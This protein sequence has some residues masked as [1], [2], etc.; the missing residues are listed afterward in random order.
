M[1]TFEQEFEKIQKRYN[2]G[3]DIVSKKTMQDSIFKNPCVLYGCGVFG[4]VLYE[5]FTR[6]GRKI[7]CFVDGNK[8]GIESTSGLEIISPDELVLRYPNASIC[9]SVVTPRPA[10]EIRNK[11]YDLGFGEDQIFDFPYKLITTPFGMETISLSYEE[12]QNHRQG[13]EYAYNLFDDDISKSIVIDRINSLLFRDYMPYI[14][15][16]ECYFPADLFSLTDKEVFVD[17]GV[18]TGDTIEEFY[19]RTDG[20]YKKIIGF[21]FD[22][23]N[24]NKALIN[25]A[26]YH[27]VSLI[28]KGLWDKE[29]SLPAVTGHDKGSNVSINGETTVEL[30]TIDDYFRDKS[31]SDYPTYIK[32]DIEGSEK[33]AILGSTSVIKAVKPKLAISMYHL[34]EDIYEIPNM[35]LKLHPDYK[36]ALRHY[37]PYAWETVL[38]AY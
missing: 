37:S 13:Y 3:E 31:V 8:K 11:L 18:Y 33:Q 21:E 16:S 30:T 17:A 25:T 10:K 20:Q 15:E 28:P 2:S 29:C 23:I 22:N 4:K 5:N 24:Y 34:P 1:G 27:D 35:I 7:E 6:E 12:I 26:D 19:K 14:P 36:L 32:M 9:I 38:Y